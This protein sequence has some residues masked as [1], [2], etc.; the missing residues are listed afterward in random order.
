MAKKSWNEFVFNDK[1]EN[2]NFF[3]FCIIWGD[4]W[5]LICF[6]DDIPLFVSYMTFTQLATCDFVIRIILSF[7]SW[8]FLLFCSFHLRSTTIHFPHDMT[9]HYKFSSSLH[10]YSAKKWIKYKK[11]DS[12]LLYQHIDYILHSIA[13]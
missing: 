2:V 8:V 3:I 7:F 13:I 9:T 6:N 5:H 4:A 1:N 11:C 12:V 10:K